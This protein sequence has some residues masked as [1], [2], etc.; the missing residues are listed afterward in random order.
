MTI[1][2][3]CSCRPYGAPFFGGLVAPFALI[4]ILN[5]IIFVLIFVSLLRK[6]RNSEVGVKKDDMKMKV[7]RQFIAAL[8]LS[9]LLGLGWGVGFAIT[10]GISSVPLST[11]LDVIFILLT[12]FQGFH[13]FIMHCIRVEEARKVWK[14][15]V[16]IAT[17]HKVT[18]NA[19]KLAGPAVTHNPKPQHSTA[20]DTKNKV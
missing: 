1:L 10:G 12:G 18:F 7:R 2:S 8:T 5:W 11:T 15:W 14:E 3:P 17:C 9:V 19:K 16:Y 20:R 6:R 13:I 4:Y